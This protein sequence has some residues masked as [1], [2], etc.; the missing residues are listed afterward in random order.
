MCTLSQ[1]SVS[2]I[3]SAS[4][5][6]SPI[7]FSKNIRSK[8]IACYAWLHRAQCRFLRLT[9]RTST[10]KQCVLSIATFQFL[11]SKC[12]TRGSMSFCYLKS[13]GFMFMPR[14]RVSTVGTWRCSLEVWKWSRTWRAFTWLLLGRPCLWWKA[15]RCPNWLR[16]EQS[17]SRSSLGLRSLNSALVDWQALSIWECEL[18]RSSGH[19]VVVTS[20]PVETKTLAQRESTR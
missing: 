10:V 7:L 18:V 6:S 20:L 9:A 13:A 12:T 15:R 8:T 17:C 16:L 11:I 14:K 2:T 5:R 3:Y 1:T 19:P 4:K